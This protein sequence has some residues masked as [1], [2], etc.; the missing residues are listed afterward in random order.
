MDW[1]G[2]NK[3]C[4]LK[5]IKSNHTIYIILYHY[6]LKKNKKQWAALRWWSN[7]DKVS[8]PLAGVGQIV[9]Q[10][11][12]LA[13]SAAAPAKSGYGSYIIATLTRSGHGHCGAP[14]F[15]HGHHSMA[16]QILSRA[17]YPWPTLTMTAAHIV[18]I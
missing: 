11:G 8:V 15:S 5:K 16:G 13:R 7:P 2:L 3:I 18:F 12:C 9:A 14:E 6:F 17:N 4:F 10:G 1:I